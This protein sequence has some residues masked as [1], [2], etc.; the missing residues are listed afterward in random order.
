LQVYELV[1][2]AKLSD[3]SVF[4]I[5][6]DAGREITQE[7]CRR[8]FQNLLADRFKLRTHREERNI[9]VYALTAQAGGPNL[10]LASESDVLDFVVNGTPMQFLGKERPKG[11]P[12]QALATVLRTGIVDR[13]VIDYTGL[14]GVYRISLNFEAGPPGVPLPGKQPDI[15]DALRKIG[16][17]FEQRKEPIQVLIVDSVE[18]PDA[19]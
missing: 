2:N 14:T 19:N 17:K 6:A 16:L 10:E 11:W 7:Q 4:D 8:M 9:D 15:F 13:P 12:M 18:M 5:E 1:W 3:Y